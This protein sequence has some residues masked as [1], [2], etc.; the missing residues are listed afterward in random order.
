MFRED[1]IATRRHSPT[2]RAILTRY[3]RGEPVYKGRDSFDRV[4]HLL[5]IHESLRS[6][7]PRNRN[8]AYAWSRTGNQVFEN[9][10]PIEHI[11]EFRLAGLVSV[12]AHLDWARDA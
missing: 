4:G 9:C 8:L 12:R 7:F 11:C 1:D 3:R 6:L 2:S 5:G 10:S